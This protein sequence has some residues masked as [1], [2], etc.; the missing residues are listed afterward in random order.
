[1]QIPYA[2]G[3]LDVAVHVTSMH[4]GRSSE[5]TGICIVLV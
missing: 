1:M 5:N 2:L 3:R 4:L